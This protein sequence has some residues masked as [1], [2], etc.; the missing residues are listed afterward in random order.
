MV[1]TEVVA[2]QAS[3]HGG[4]GGGGRSGICTTWW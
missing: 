3:A 2:G 1:V 4:D